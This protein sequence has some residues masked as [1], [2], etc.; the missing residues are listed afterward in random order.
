MKK[1]NKIIRIIAIVLM[2]FLIGLIIS[3]S[4]NASWFD[5][6]REDIEGK[7]AAGGGNAGN[8][9]TS[10]MGAA[11]SITSTVAAGVGIIMIIVLGIQYTSKSAEAKAEAKKD[12]TGYII[13]AVLLFGA[14]GILK[15]MQMFIDKNLNNV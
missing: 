8:K 7:A 11:I 3:N 13:G 4:V 6:V 5:S 1:S 12:L 15:L 10:I 9:V 14:S 2:L